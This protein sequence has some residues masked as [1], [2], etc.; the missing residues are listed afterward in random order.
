M[1]DCTVISIG[2]EITIPATAWDLAGFRQWAKSARF[3]DRGR[4][5]FLDG[6]MIVD[7]SPEEINNH[8]QIKT[9]VGFAINGLNKQLDIGKF[10][11][12][13]VLVTNL[14][15]GLAT[16]PDATLVTWTGFQSGRVKLVPRA[17]DEEEEYLELEGTPDW[18]LE[19]VS[20]YSVRKDTKQLR[21]IY[22]RAGIPEYWLVDARG[23]R[24]DFK[25]LQLEPDGYG[26]SPKRGGWLGS[27]LFGCEFRLE[28]TR[29]RLGLWQYTLEVR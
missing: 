20:K 9:E 4:V 7:M 18:V 12:D 2:R 8:N 19:I 17:A 10:F 26:V 28:R 24:I 15:A 3:E 16:E 1:A 5:A 13:R 27:P 21:E 6:E 11:S 23:K 25:I 22:H 29:D 14:S